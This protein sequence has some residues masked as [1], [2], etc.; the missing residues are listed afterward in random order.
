[1]E[2]FLI[3]ML[4]VILL[5]AAPASW[6]EQGENAST[7]VSDLVIQPGEELGCEARDQGQGASE[8]ENL[9]NSGCC[10]ICTVGKAC[11]DT[12]I[13]RSYTCTKGAGCACDG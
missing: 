9:A 10:K 5:A 1:M 4:T 13:S 11:G 7:L 12:C 3:G 2:K 6:S 8:S